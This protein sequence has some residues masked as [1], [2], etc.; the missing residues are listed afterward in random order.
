MFAH[1][2]FFKFTDQADA[3]EAKRRL[4]SMRGVVS[5]L[6]RIEVG[7][8]VMGSARS[9]HMVLDTRFDNRA[10][11]EAYATD[12]AHLEVLGWLKTVVAESSTVDYVSP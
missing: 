11:Y 12:P 7:L 8:D 2:V 1:I 6:Q 9:W 5:S 3:P 4:E 10:G